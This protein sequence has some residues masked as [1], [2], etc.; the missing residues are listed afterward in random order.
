MSYSDIVPGTKSKQVSTSLSWGPTRLRYP[1]AQLL[2]PGRA[3]SLAQNGEGRPPRRR[4]SNTSEA[5]SESK[6]H[7]PPGSSSVQSGPGGA[8]VRTSSQRLA[9][10]S[11][12][13]P[14]PGPL[15]PSL[16]LDF[17]LSL[18]A[19][20]GEVLGRPQ[21]GKPFPSSQRGTKEACAPGKRRTG[22]PYSSG[23]GSV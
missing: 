13:P 9:P 1:A 17:P 4:R 3:E 11:C 21:E 15:P 20:S 12:V 5:Q 7:T 23:E 10:L 6:M 14:P 22:G 16:T 8:W 18:H 19:D 2:V